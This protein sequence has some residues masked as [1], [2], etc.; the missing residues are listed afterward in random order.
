MGAVTTN[1]APAD[2]CS[3]CRAPVIAA[4]SG[5]LLD[6][7]PHRLGVL[8]PDGSTLTAVPDFTPQ[9]IESGDESCPTN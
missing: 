4:P 5:L 3:T 6:P 8:R 2:V 7:L 9:L 1:P